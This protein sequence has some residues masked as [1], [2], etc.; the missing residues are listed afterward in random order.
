MYW[1]GFKVKGMTLSLYK[2]L[3]SAIKQD[4]YLSKQGLCMYCWF[5]HLL[6][7]NA[8]IGACRGALV[9]WTKHKG[10]KIKLAERVP[11]HLAVAGDT[12]ASVCLIMDADA[13]LRAK[14]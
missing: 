3:T 11:R 12:V 2:A 14:C 1:L 6:L 7:V 10:G 9:R 8:C 13:W 5:M 4:L